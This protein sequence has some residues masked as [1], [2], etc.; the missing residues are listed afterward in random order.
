MMIIQIFSVK[1]EPYSFRRII[2]FQNAQNSRKSEHKTEHG[3]GFE[4]AFV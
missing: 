4:K 3:I 1:K 2:G